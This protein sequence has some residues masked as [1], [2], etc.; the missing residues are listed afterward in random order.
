MRR[1][2]N[3]AAARVRVGTMPVISSSTCDGHVRGASAYSL[4]RRKK[5]RTIRSGLL[6]VPHESRTGS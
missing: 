4:P 6:K 5:G 2:T 3:W 1:W